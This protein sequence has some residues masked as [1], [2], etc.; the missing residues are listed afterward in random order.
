M[1]EICTYSE[2]N[3]IVHSHYGIGQIKGIDVKDISGEETRYCRI[4]TTGSTFWVP[5]DQMDSEVLRPLSTPEEIQQAIAVLQ[6]PPEEMSSNYQIRQKRIQQARIRN[7]PRAIARIIRDLRALRRDKGG[8]NSTEHNAYLNLKQRLAEE[9]AL[10]K[11]AKTE[12][13][14]SKIDEL[15][16]PHGASADEQGSATAPPETA[17]ANSPLSPQKQKKLWVW[18]RQQ[19]NKIKR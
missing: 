19:A 12:K 1:E 14:V 16:D 11:N 5:L 15:L 18:S 13:V 2:G 6:K 4:E 7:T 17:A 3:W 10:V 8:L 9:W